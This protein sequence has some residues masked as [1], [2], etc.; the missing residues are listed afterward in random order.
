MFTV[1][2]RSHQNHAFGYCFLNMMF[3]LEVWLYTLGLY[4]LRATVM[5]TPNPWKQ[6]WEKYNM[7]S[8]M[9]SMYEIEENLAIERMKG[10]KEQYDYLKLHREYLGMKSNLLDNHLES[11]RVQLKKHTYERALAILRTTDMYE[12]NNLSTYMNE[13]LIEAVANMKATISGKE[14]SSIKQQA[15]ESALIGIR[16]GS[17]TYEKD[18]L[19][20]ILLKEIDAMQEKS[21]AMTDD[22]I[23]K[24]VQLDA[25]QKKMLMS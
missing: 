25:D 5:I 15:F 2:M 21:K 11:S 12:N 23:T 19:L 16:K 6:M 9:G 22:Q 14:A 18:P 24:I 4:L 17:M 7:D 20:P 13:Q 3:G 1:S 10:P 8:M